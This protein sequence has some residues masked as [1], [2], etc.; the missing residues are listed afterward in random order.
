MQKNSNVV[1]LPEQISSGV[2]GFVCVYS[3]ID[4]KSYHLRNLVP[5]YSLIQ[6]E[7]Q[8]L[9]AAG[10]PLKVSSEKTVQLPSDL[11]SIYPKLS[12]REC[13]QYLLELC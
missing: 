3:V 5:E 2:D 9:H 7:P 10:N 12:K 6:P 8:H 1:I 4:Y 11:D 13:F